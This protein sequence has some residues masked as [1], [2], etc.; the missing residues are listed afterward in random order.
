MRKLY[1]PETTPLKRVLLL[2]YLLK[3]LPHR[4]ASNRPI[5]LGNH[6]HIL[7]EGVAKGTLVGRGYVLS[8]GEVRKGESDEEERGAY[9][10]DV[11]IIL[12][13][14]WWHDTS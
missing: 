7:D 12:V 9:L 11:Y 6:T 3:A 14:S 10:P 5:T 4:R 8:W 13:L 2:C 1:T